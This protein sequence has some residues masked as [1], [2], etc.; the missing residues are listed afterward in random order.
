MVEYFLLPLFSKVWKCRVK[1][2][3]SGQTFF[4]IV[5]SDLFFSAEGMIQI[6]FMDYFKIMFFYCENNYL[7]NK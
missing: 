6:S 3:V 7:N 2:S 4:F 1:A 5:N